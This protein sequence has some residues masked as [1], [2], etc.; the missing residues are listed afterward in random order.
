VHVDTIL[1]VTRVR[2]GGF[3]GCECAVSIGKTQ[4]MLARVKKVWQTVVTH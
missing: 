3:T 2:R 4:D 1:E